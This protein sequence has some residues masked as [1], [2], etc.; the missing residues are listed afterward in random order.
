MA[1]ITLC[2]PE[3]RNTLDL[4]SAGLLEQCV[5]AVSEREDLTM[6]TLTGQ[7]DS[8]CAGTDPEYLAQIQAA[9]D[10]ESFRQFLRIGR[11]LLL[12]LRRMPQLVIASVNGVAS[13]PGFGLVLASDWAV[14]S[15]K[16]CLGETSVSDGLFP[17]WTGHWLLQERLGPSKAIELVMLGQ[18]IPAG[19]AF[20]KGLIHRVTSA[21]S[22]AE[23][24]DQITTR[25]AE[26]PPLVLREMKKTAYENHYRGCEAKSDFEIDGQIRCFL[27]EDSRAG[28]QATLR[29]RKAKFEGR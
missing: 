4:D 24:T 9:G 22:L 7:G 29:N 18:L 19:E 28:V 20:A 8:F 1:R 5:R 2:R 26:A 3:R 25:L 15:E 14:A 10:I 6:L 16:A 17:G 21:D 13:G 11:N 27:S 23:C 12:L